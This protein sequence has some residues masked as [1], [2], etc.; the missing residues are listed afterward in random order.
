MKHFLTKIR[1]RLAAGSLLLTMGAH[2]ATSADLYDSLQR[3][4]DEIGITA[5]RPSESGWTPGGIMKL[6]NKFLRKNGFAEPMWAPEEVFKEGF[7]LRDKLTE[8]PVSLVDRKTS[9]VVGGAANFQAL[10]LLGLPFSAN[11]AAKYARDFEVVYT[12]PRMLRLREGT[13]YDNR[14]FIRPDRLMSVSPITRQGLFIPL[15]I[16]TVRGITVKFTQPKD[17]KGLAES[18][19]E[20]N[21]GVQK[22]Q[23][24]GQFVFS[25]AD[26]QSL[27]FK[28]ADSQSALAIGFGEHFPLTP[29]NIAHLKPARNH[30]SGFAY[31]LGSSA[32]VLESRGVA[33]VDSGASVFK[34]HSVSD[35]EQLAEVEYR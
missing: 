21:L 7:N 5:F 16:L 22:N 20:V 10:E 6:K 24:G 9:L 8:T 35:L 28:V 32:V 31:L 18:K 34:D 30:S 15:K 26:D 27:T 1:F 13:L 25:K 11:L 29:A 14:E 2:P 19:I 12:E 23:D 3:E 33:K 4:L 17:A